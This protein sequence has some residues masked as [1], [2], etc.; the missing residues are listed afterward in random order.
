MSWSKLRRESTT[1]L[2]TFKIRL[3]N[4]EHKYFSKG[5]KENRWKDRKHRS[6]K[7]CTEKEL[8]EP[9]KNRLVY[10]SIPKTVAED[11]TEKTRIWPRRVH[12]NQRRKRRG[13][14]QRTNYNLLQRTN[15]PYCQEEQKQN[16]TSYCQIQRFWNK[17]WVFEGSSLKNDDRSK[18]F[19]S[20]DL[21]PT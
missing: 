14:W 11:L 9:K 8:I 10:F 19:F 12:W 13:I 1:C 17:I 3:R 15:V 5:W 7:I 21:T 2:P 6:W 4:W 18:N 16:K 20:L